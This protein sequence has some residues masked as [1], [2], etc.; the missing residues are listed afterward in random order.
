MELGAVGKKEFLRIM[1]LAG[2]PEGEKDV[3]IAQGKTDIKKK[4]SIEWEA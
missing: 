4:V 2:I 3:T 1:R